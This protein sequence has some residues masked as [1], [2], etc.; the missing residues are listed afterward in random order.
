MPL[1]RK[2]RIRT[3]CGD[4]DR[5]RRVGDVSTCGHRAKG[6]Q[7]GRQDKTGSPDVLHATSSYA[8]AN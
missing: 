8:H 6:E 7:H 2:Q 3:R 5:L 1:Y 4:R